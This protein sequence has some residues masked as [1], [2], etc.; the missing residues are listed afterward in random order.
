MISARVFCVVVKLNNRTPKIRATH[1][2]TRTLLRVAGATSHLENFFH[3]KRAM[4]RSGHL[5]KGQPLTMTTEQA[6]P[7][8]LLLRLDEV[9]KILALGR[10][11]VYNLVNAGELPIVRI[12]KSIRIPADA[13]EAWVEKKTRGG[14][15]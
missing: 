11:T 12:G 6:Q 5:A 14:K 13:L 2:N 8:R 4:L 9:A 3:R 1:P 10:S 7:E 15:E